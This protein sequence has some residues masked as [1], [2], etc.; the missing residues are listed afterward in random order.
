[1]KKN[2]K[3]FDPSN[4]NRIEWIESINDE[5]DYLNDDI[6]TLDLPEDVI[7]KIESEITK[8]RERIKDTINGLEI[9]PTIAFAQED[10]I[11]NMLFEA[12]MPAKESNAIIGEY[13]LNTMVDILEHERGGQFVKA[14]SLAEQMKLEAFLQDYAA[15]P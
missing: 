3:K 8:F 2:K 9:T 4:G 11:D 10:L 5:I 15:N 12:W 7:K 6:N 14:E 1:M 13:G